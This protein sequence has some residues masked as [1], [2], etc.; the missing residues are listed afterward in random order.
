MP[1]EAKYEVIVIGG[2][3]AG[4]VAAIT[5]ARNGCRVALVHDRP[6]LGGNSSNEVRIGITGAESKGTNRNARETGILEE[7]RL[8]CAYRDRLSEGNG[9]PRPM[10]DW[11]LWEWVTREPAITLYLNARA[12]SAIMQSPMEIAGV[13]VDQASTERTFRLNAEIFIDCSGDGQIAAD[14]GAEFR[15]GRESHQEFG[16]SRARDEADDKVLCPSLLFSAHDAGHAVPYTPPPWARRFPSD[17][18]LPLRPHFYVD[19][20]YWFI[21]YGGTLDPIRDSEQIRD[22]LVRIVFG[23]WDHVKNHGDHGAE[24]YVLDWVGAV[25][26]KRESRRFVGDHVL[27]QGDIEDQ[28]LF[29]DRVAYCGWALDH[30]HP[31]EGIY[32]KN[33]PG[34]W[35]QM[36]YLESTRGRAYPYGTVVK[37]LY[38]D[39]PSQWPDLL[40]P[41][42]GLASI[43]F[44]CLYSKNIENLLFAGRHISATHIAFGSTRVQGTC[45]IVGQAVGTAAAM[46]IEY[47]VRPRGLGQTRIGELQRRLLKDDCH[48]IAVRNIDP[49]DLALKAATCA[50]S[51]ALL[52]VTAAGEWMPLDFGRGQMISFSSPYVRTVS[53]LLRSER[54]EAVELSAQLV[55]ATRLDDFHLPEVVAS[56]RSTLLP[57]GEWWVDLDFETGIEPEWP[58]WIKLDATSGVSW[59]YTSWEPIGTQRAEWYEDLGQWRHVRGTHCFRTSPESRPYGAPNVVNGMAR[60]EVGPGIWISDASQELPQ[61]VELQF[62]EPQSVDTVHLTFDTNL[63][64]MPETGP[65]P[66]CVRDYRVLIDDGTGYHEAVAVRGNYQRRRIHRFPRTRAARVRLVVEATHGVPQARVYEIRLYCEGPQTR[67]PCARGGV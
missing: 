8:E 20:G 21:E 50:S 19:R 12:R 32:S 66:E 25:L 34:N 27:T 55:R 17:D 23:V 15:M 6:T 39:P 11:L 64:R 65:V 4:T 46:C 60:A 54:S 49:E 31:P 42:R 26:G 35:P 61:W 67:A 47:G 45:A 13:V 24:N 9:S 16:E 51:S 37:S 48:I 40:P 28:V 30:L 43:P 36:L 10:W 3:V 38:R 62:R 7:I 2:G 5:A 52:E 57:H 53:L 14:A 33:A 41:L 18:D 59:A 63:D 29:S 58:H 1:D 56:V 44:R 22:E